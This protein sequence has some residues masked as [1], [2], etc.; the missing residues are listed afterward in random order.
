M[1]QPRYNVVNPG[2]YISKTPDCKKERPKHLFRSL[3]D[4]AQT[5]Q[6]Q[7]SAHAF[8]NNTQ[9]PCNVFIY[10]SQERCSRFNIIA[11]VYMGNIEYT[12]CSTVYSM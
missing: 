10:Y 4:V 3:P 6:R 2:E 1:Q 12:V 7:T 9:Y 5:V 8:I 11:L